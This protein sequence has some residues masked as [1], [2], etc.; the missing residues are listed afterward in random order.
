MRPVEIKV[1]AIKK[2]CT[3]RLMSEKTCNYKKQKA[4]EKIKNRCKI[5]ELNNNNNNQLHQ[6][7]EKTKGP[8]AMQVSIS[9][10]C[11]VNFVGSKT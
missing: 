5:R 11:V 7:G 10:G 1:T 2:E 8:M 6:S 4:I 9:S 3:A